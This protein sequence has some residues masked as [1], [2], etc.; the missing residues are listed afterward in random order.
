MLSAIASNIK[1]VIILII[2]AIIIAD[3]H[4]LQSSNVNLFA[5]MCSLRI[6]AFI[7]LFVLRQYYYYYYHRRY[8]CQS[9]A[10][11]KSV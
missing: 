6:M 3:A 4:T 10:I 5:R 9:S 8:C 2:I 1:I 11:S 7:L